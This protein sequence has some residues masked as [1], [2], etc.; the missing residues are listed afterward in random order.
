MASFK[1]SA[2]EKVARTRSSQGLFARLPAGWFVMNDMGGSSGEVV[3]SAACADTATQD[4]YADRA[5][6]CQHELGYFFESSTTDAGGTYRCNYCHVAGLRAA[7]SLCIVHRLSDAAGS[8]ERTPAAGLT[9]Y[10]LHLDQPE[11]PMETT[12]VRVVDSSTFVTPPEPQ[13]GLGLRYWRWDGTKGVDLHG[14]RRCYLSRVEWD[15]AAGVIVAAEEEALA[16]IGRAAFRGA[17][18]S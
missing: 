2:C 16:V 1:C 15:A 7:S 17:V 6:T 5:K 11:Q 18:A 3:C 12:I 13:R 8:E 4:I 14:D 10:I 9:V